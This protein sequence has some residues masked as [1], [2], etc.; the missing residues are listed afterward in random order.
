MAEAEAVREGM[1][2]IIH[3][4]IMEDGIR[5]VVE[6]DSKGLVQCLNKEAIADV[7]LEVYLHDIWRMMR[8]FQLVKVCFTPRQCNRAAHSVAVCC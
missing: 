3:C 6:S 2:A 8:F 7:S 1:E 4:E 5:L